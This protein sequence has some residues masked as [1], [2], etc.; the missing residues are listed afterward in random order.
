MSRRDKRKEFS[1]LKRKNMYSVILELFFISLMIL[2]VYKIIEWWKDNHKNEEIMNNISQKIIFDEFAIDEEDKYK[3]DFNGLKQENENIVAWIKVNGTGIE[4]PVVKYR[5][6]EFYLKHS[7]DNSYNKAGW[8]FAD[9]RNK[10]DG[11][12]KNLIIYGHNR[13]NDSMFGTLKDILNEEWYNNEENRKVIF[14]T[15]TEKAVY[16]VFSV[17]RIEDE[18]Y[19]IK[20]NFAGNEFQNFINTLKRRSIREFNIDVTSEDKILTLSTCDNDNNY[21]VVLHARKITE[22]I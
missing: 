6:N 20:T 12:D 18:D 22:N 3:I 5:D 10:F 15:E 9:Y 19:Y 13:R 1:R 7:L 8:I 17:Y 14:I 21:R 11:S 16:Q 2:S 4:Y